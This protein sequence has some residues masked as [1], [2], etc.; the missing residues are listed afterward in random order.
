MT[1]E[2]EQ[3]LK[4]FFSRLGL[5][6]MACDEAKISK[7]QV[8]EWIESDKDFAE[9]IIS[10]QDRRLDFAEAQLFSQ[11]QNGNIEAVKTYLNKHGQ[12]R[13]WGDIK[14]PNG[15]GNEVK[16]KKKIIQND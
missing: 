12:S 8:E 15:G 10:I 7:K 14:Q 16:K 11:M 9:E 13:G 3:F 1:E 2:K 5:M 4:I 6:S